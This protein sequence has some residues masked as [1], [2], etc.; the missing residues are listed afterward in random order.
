MYLLVYIVYTS[1]WCICAFCYAHTSITLEVCMLLSYSSW[2]WSQWNS[3]IAL[4]S[5][6]KEGLFHPTFHILHIVPYMYI[7]MY[8]NGMHF[9]Y[10]C[11]EWYDSYMCC[12]APRQ[13]VYIKYLYCFHI[14]SGFA[15]WNCCLVF[16]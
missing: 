2:F 10:V 16:V 4:M 7:Y 1:M 9:V 8:L 3:C 11:K 15:P 6:G 13:V 12:V 14:H 5:Q